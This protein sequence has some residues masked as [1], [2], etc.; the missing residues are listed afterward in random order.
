MTGLL[1]TWA[2]TAANNPI[3]S[4]IVPPHMR[5]LIYAF[6]RSFEGAIA[7]AGIFINLNI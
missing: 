7:A 3:F 6:D 2:A 1:I 4:E 5:N